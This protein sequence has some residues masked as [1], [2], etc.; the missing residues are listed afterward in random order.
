MNIKIFALAAILSVTAA[1]T[2]FAQAISGRGNNEQVVDRGCEAQ[3]TLVSENVG[4]VRTLVENILNCGAQYKM[5]HQATGQCRDIV[6]PDYQFSE[7][8]DQL[9]VKFEGPTEGVYNQG[10]YNVRGAK[11]PDGPSA[12]PNL[13]APGFSGKLQP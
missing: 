6:V 3:I 9:I 2:A 5:Y 10:N 4:R 11:G 7:V 8:G 1:S 13:C 12:N